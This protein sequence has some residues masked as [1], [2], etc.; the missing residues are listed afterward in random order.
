MNMIYVLGSLNMDYTAK[1]RMP[2]RGETVLADD[3]GIFC[4]GKGANQAAAAAKLGGRTAMIGCVG[5]DDGGR[6]LI[7]NLQSAGA[8]TSRVSIKQEAP[9]GAALILVGGKGDNRIVVCTGANALCTTADIDEAL[10]DAEAGDIL[11]AQLEIP[12]A[13]VL[14]AFTLAK[15]KG[16]TTVL[17]PAPAAADLPKELF[18][19]TDII[20]PNETETEILTGVNPVDI[21]HVA[22]SA[23]AFHKKGIQKIVLTLGSRG[24]AVIDGHT[25]TEIDAVKVKVVDTTAAG[26]TFVGAAVVDEASLGNPCL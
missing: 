2:K 23:K 16:M 6:R 19:A 11:A 14:Y 9:T 13:V 12:I 7:E 20:I 5:D 3:Y 1:T 22:L 17:N 24:A 26:D 10:R 8:D 15:S 21:V 18:S 25:V 4:G